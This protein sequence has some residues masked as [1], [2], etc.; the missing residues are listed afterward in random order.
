MTTKLIG[1]AAAPGL[2]KGRLAVWGRRGLDV[3]RFHPADLDAERQ[4]LASARQAAAAQLHTL[5]RDVETRI[6]AEEAALFE[7]HAMFLD[8]PALLD[9]AEAD[10]A[11]GENA[12]WAWHEASEHFAAQLEALTDPTLRARAADIRD[13]SRRVVLILLGSEY[14]NTVDIQGVLAA[15]DLS[16]S[17]T[18][19]LD[20]D[21]V[22]AFCTAEGGPTSHTAILAR[23]L[24]I[25]AV[26]GLGDAVLEIKAGTLLL[27]DGNQGE[28]LVAPDP[29]TEE[30][31]ASKMSLD[32][33]KN[34]QQARLA[35]QP[36]I[37]KDGHRIEVA[38]NVG[39]VKDA[40]TARDLGAD[41]IGLLRTEFLYLQREKAPT[42]DDQF[43]AY[44]T[45]FEVMGA[46]PVVVRTMDI[47]GDKILP[48]LDL[49]REDNPF[50][51]WRAIR[52]SLSRP[53]LFQPQLRA[54]LR[55]AVGH[56]IR[57]MF[58]MIATVEEIR[59]ARAAVKEARDE[60]SKEGQP[61]AENFQ[62]GMMVEIPSAA[63][64]ADMFAREVDFFSIGTNDLTQYAMAAERTNKRVA[65]LSDAIHP[66]ILRLIKQVTNAAH[67][68]QRWVGVCGELGGDADAVPVLVGLGVD[69]LSVAPPLVAQVK[70]VIRS[71]SLA[72]AEG[73]ATDALMQETSAAVRNL[74]R[75]R[76]V[77]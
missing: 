26:V 40:W 19:A 43:E 35:H 61:V 8:D 14:S 66:A 68:A 44:R 71:W 20:T 15:R 10:I 48:Y 60:L 24:G 37:T 3:P 56:E 59:T 23:A 70:A 28:I 4:R 49:G 1:I 18:A 16:P 53:D 52:I 30:A 25:P 69:E 7:A 55:A 62:L 63:I 32:R 46:R 13:V 72:E 73:L 2:A 54:I 64:M 5:A 57:I 38:A 65:Y 39:S 50:L 67:A 75:T 47:G 58:P 12:E 29:E 27:V 17:E 9:W 42:E 36:A 11:G 31:F 21:R 6:G 45:I 22:A 76:E 74:V 51:G 33:L 77:R 41:G 34:T